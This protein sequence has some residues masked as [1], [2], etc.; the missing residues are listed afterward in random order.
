MSEKSA[1]KT[2]RK[3]TLSECPGSHWQRLEDSI[4]LGV[5][6]I[7]VA[8]VL[9]TSWRKNRGD[10]W[11]EAKELDVL[12]KRNTTPVR[13]GLRLEQKLWLEE[14]KKA[15]RRVVVAV[16]TPELWLF[17]DDYFQLLYDGLPWSM[18]LIQARMTCPVKDLRKRIRDIYQELLP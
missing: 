6:D 17:F 15:G 4:S 12:P 5:P 13:V 8:V 2:L 10:L 1:V 3:H 16:R 9:D 14:G 11:I 7:N 18:L